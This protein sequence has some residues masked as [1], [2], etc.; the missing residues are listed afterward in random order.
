MLELATDVFRR[1]LEEEYPC[2]VLG[3]PG[4]PSTQ[5]NLEAELVLPLDCVRGF[6]MNL[7]IPRAEHRTTDRVPRASP[8]HAALLEH[9][10]TNHADIVEEKDI[11]VN[12]YVAP[13]YLKKRGMMYR[14][15]IVH[16][17]QHHSTSV[18]ELFP[19]QNG[20]ATLCNLEHQG[21]RSFVN[22]SRPLGRALT[23]VANQIEKYSRFAHVVRAKQKKLFSWRY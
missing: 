8:L 6:T 2:E 19:H 10:A 3:Y 23:Y 13:L 12:R 20:I 14:A 9:I 5:R 16:N 15:A 22:P 7:V 17:P 18:E 21:D 4:Q 1:V 11:K